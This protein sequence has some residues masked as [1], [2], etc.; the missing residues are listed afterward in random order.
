MLPLSKD[1]SNNG[2]HHFLDYDDSGKTLGGSSSINGAAWTRASAAQYDAWKSL[3][4]PEE[5]YLNW[6]WNSMFDYMNKVRL[7]L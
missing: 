4:K 5:A 2:T 3:L 7:F 6:T 1:S